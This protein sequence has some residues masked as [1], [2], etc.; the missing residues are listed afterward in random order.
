LKKL[1]GEMLDRVEEHEAFDPRTHFE[2]TL[3]PAEMNAD[4]RF[5]AGIERTPDDIALDLS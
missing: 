1:V 2:L 3:A 4:E 5:A